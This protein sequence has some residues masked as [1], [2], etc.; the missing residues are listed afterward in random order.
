M[1]TK[2]DEIKWEL[3]KKKKS[4]LFSYG[5]SKGLIHSY[6]KQLIENL[7]HVYYGG[8]PASI[9]LL[10][11]SICG[12]YC[13]DRALLVTLGFG[14][15]D[16]QLVDADIDGINLNPMYIDTSCGDEHYGNHCFAERT[17]KDGT[18]WVYDTSLGLVIEKNL[19][20]KIERPKITKINSKQA[21]LDYCE[22]KDIKNA[23]IENDKYMLPLILPNI[24]HAANK[25]I[26]FYSQFLREEIKRFKQEIDYDGICREI[27]ED[28]KRKRLIK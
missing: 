8:V 4:I 13:Y 25:E 21:T 10:C 3:Y 26:E 28:M 23:R 2:L 17:K 7:R 22:Y 16:F 5:I 19:Y 14:D 15:D 27:N 1:A 9:I 6:E 20:Y 18:T 24:E 11:K 12:G